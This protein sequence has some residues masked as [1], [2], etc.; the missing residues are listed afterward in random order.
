M[1]KL[2]VQ[3]MQLVK[4]G[5]IYLVTVLTV[6]VLGFADTLVF[7]DGTVL[8]GT[9]RGGDE[10]SLRFEVEG[11]LQ[12]I[13]LHKVMS[14]TFTSREA[15]AETAAAPAIGSTV[16][17]PAGTRM[18]VKLTQPLGTATHGQGTS[19]SAALA[20]GLA[21]GGDVVVPPGTKIY[22][23]VLESRGG[24][25]LGGT[26]LVVAFTDLEINSQLIP[27]ATDQIGAEAG[28]GGTLRKVGA[29]ALIGLAIDG[30]SGAG[31][32]AA[33]GGALAL[34]TARRNHIQ[35]PAGYQVEVSLKQPL[36][37]KT[38]RKGE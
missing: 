30:G 8:Q 32:G 37:L 24:R 1:Y 21:V 5:F 17:I 20:T 28:R 12:T 18:I 13:A 19:F 3:M 26:K 25:V 38:E 9:Y 11:K 23:R 33:V 16:T 14:I 29:G 2:E 22:G 15:S 31:T 10:S 4:Q 6:A 7:K 27:I 35:I 34:L 36:N